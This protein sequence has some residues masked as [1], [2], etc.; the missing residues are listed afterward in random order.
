MQV[1]FLFLVVFLFVFARK[2]VG[3]FGTNIVKRTTY[4][5]MDDIDILRVNINEQY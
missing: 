1:V 3:Q 2:V 5:T 4:W